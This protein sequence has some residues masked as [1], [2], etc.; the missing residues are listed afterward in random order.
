MSGMSGAA[1]I[2]PRHLQLIVKIAETG[3]LQLAAQAAA[4]TQPAASRILADLEAQFEQSFFV[5][6]ANG[7]KPTLA[8]EVLVRHAKV[9]MAGLDTLTDELADLSLGNAGH[10][11]VGAVTGAAVGHLMPAAQ[12]ILQ[13][14]PDVRISVDVAPST[15]LF[16][17]L[18]ESRYDFILGRANPRSTT[19]DFRFYPGRAETV[20]LLVGETHPLAGLA[21]VNLSELADYPW[22]IQEEG[23]P[24]REAVEQAFH[25]HGLPVPGRVLN[26]SSLLVAL[27]Q[28][29]QADAIAPQ[30]QEVLR[31]L[32]SDTIHAGVVALQ[33]DIP[34]TVS[35]YFVIVS[36]QRKLP[37]AAERLFDAVNK[38]F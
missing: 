20:S 9:V 15:A 4:I 21:S 8:G 32:V 31:L 3:Q 37:R 29:A 36:E 38:R 13:Q 22:V 10:V 7:M 28:I 25:Q 18:E 35:P 26:S 27:A 2:K 12:E 19:K 5:R 6:H 11:R 34:I 17:G 24:I 16:R 23:S 30:T 1:R 14:T 33:T